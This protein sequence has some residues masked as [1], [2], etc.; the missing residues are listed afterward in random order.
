M[1]HVGPPPEEI[2]HLTRT[3]AMP[4]DGFWVQG[5]A[6]R[7]REHLPKGLYEVSQWVIG[8]E[9]RLWVSALSIDYGFHD[10]VFVMTTYRDER[11]G[12]ELYRLSKMYPGGPSELSWSAHD[13]R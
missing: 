4:W 11:F 6:I 5:G 12:Q 3:S 10:E 9:A 13:W 2:A 1:Q 7:S 8:K